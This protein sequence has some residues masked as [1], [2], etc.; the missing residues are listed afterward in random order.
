MCWKQD[1]VRVISPK[2]TAEALSS[3]CLKVKELEAAEPVMAHRPSFYKEGPRARRRWVLK[4]KC[5]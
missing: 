2:F 4:L 1:A 5:F 3:A